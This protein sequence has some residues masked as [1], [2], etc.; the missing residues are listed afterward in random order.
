MRHRRSALSVLAAHLALVVLPGAA[1]AQGFEL[2]DVEVGRDDPKFVCAG[3]L[4][5][6]GDLDVV[7]VSEQDDLVA[8]SE[9]T[10]GIGSSW[11]A[12]VV[13]ASLDAPHCV[14]VGDLDGDGDADLTVVSKNDDT[15]S[16]IENATGDGSQWTVHVVDAGLDLP[17]YVS[18]GD[19]DGDGAPDLLVAATNDDL[20]AWFENELGSGGGWIR[21]DL[22]YAGS[23]PACALAS[24]VDGDGDVDVLSSSGPD[25]TITWLENGGGA[26]SW[27]IHVVSAASLG[28]R[29]LC[30][31]DV[32][33]DGDLDVVATSATADSL[34]WYANLDGRGRSW[35]ANPVSFSVAKVKDVHVGDIDQDG[36]LDLMTASVD[37]DKLAWFE[38]RGAGLAWIE[39]LPAL[40]LDQPSAVFLADVDADSDLDVLFATIGGDRI[41]LLRNTLDDS[42]VEGRRAL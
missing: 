14:Q 4:D 8:W 15:L 34:H 31:G 33:G 35:A 3:D 7:S 24:D 40:G 21:H 28:A 12:H 38:N 9:N 13:T 17:K 6:D 19:L 22:P 2:Q 20:L 27:T 11:T 26:A 1:V 39:Q 30:V 18:I 16:W 37:D 41:G 10:D 29:R 32:D 25:D 36:D 5:G 42:N 23:L